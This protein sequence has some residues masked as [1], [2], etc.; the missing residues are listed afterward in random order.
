M[1][2]D[3]T[4]WMSFPIAAERSKV[5]QSVCTR[6]TAALNYHNHWMR[7]C[8]ATSTCTAIAWPATMPASSGVHWDCCDA[9]G[10]AWSVPHSTSEG[11]SVWQPIEG[12]VAERAV[13]VAREVAERLREPARVEAAIAAAA[14]QTT[15]PGAVH[16]QPHALAQ[17]DAGLAIMAGYLDRCFPDEGWDV[18]GHVYLERA[19]HGAELLAVTQAG[20]WAGL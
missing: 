15:L 2:A 5:A 14:E 13:V 3:K 7:C 20:L 9:R 16:W 11:R 8:A 6:P 4:Y 18:V 19:A 12:P 1:P 17:G 10:T